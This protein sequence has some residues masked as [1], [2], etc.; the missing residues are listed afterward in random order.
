ERRQA[1]ADRPLPGGLTP[2]LMAARGDN[3]TS[4]PPEVEAAVGDLATWWAGVCASVCNRQARAEA[5]RKVIEAITSTAAALEEAGR[6]GIS[7]V[8]EKTDEVLYGWWVD[9]TWSDLPDVARLRT[10]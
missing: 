7:A 6:P 3:P 8:E 9:F 10:P 4:W 5:M 2:R 1:V